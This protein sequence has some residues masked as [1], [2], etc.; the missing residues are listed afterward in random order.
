MGRDTWMGAATSSDVAEVRPRDGDIVVAPE[1]SSP[2]RFTTRQVP[3]GPQVSWNSHD[4]AVEMARV[5]ARRY[6]VDVWTV[7]G[8]TQICRYRHRPTTRRVA[9]QAAADHRLSRPSVRLRR[10]SA[11]HRRR[12]K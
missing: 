7:D 5:F 12:R 2:G 11:P 1:P 9:A 10:S 3:A 8:Q 4:V 6:A